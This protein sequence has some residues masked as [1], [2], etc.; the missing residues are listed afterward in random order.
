MI[1]MFNDCWPC[2][3]WS[4][5]DYYFQPKPAYYATLR[6]NAPVMVT[7]IEDANRYD[8]Y[9]VNDTFKQVS[10]PLLLGQ[11]H[12]AEAPIWQYR[13]QVRIGANASQCVAQIKKSSVRAKKDTYLFARLG[14]GRKTLATRIFFHKPWRE[15]QWPQPELTWKCGAS[16]KT[17]AEHPAIEGTHYRTKLSFQAM[18]YARM[19]HIDGA[20]GI[21]LLMSDN[22]FD[23]VP[24]ESKTVDIRSARKIK[25]DQLRVRHW[26]DRW[27]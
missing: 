14:A 11:G 26:L 3:S 2:A 19:I 12:I 17:S 6:A 1:W 25:S 5:V 9:V 15:I 21:D 4:V 23:L 18:R 13:K 27:D 22:F 8:V 7:I 24:G 16:V 20:E 10:G